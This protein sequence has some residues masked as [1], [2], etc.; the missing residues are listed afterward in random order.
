VLVSTTIMQISDYWKQ[1]PEGCI[2]S[3]AREEARHGVLILIRESSA[4]RL[5][6]LVLSD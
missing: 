4:P 5:I 6:F 2:D 1:Y 3:K